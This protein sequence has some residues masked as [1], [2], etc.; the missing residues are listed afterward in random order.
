MRKFYLKVAGVV[1]ALAGLLT[2]GTAFA[3]SY[4]SITTSS[5]AST[6]AYITDFFT[7]LSPF[8]WL[9]IGVPLAFYVINRVVKMVRVGR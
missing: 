7:D 3:T 2:A 1:G 9:A 5:L 8:I 4:V 6:T